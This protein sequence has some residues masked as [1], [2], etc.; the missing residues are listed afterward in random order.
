MG[1]V[2][3]GSCI[4]LFSDHFD[5]TPAERRGRSGLLPVGRSESPRSPIALP[6]IVEKRP[7]CDHDQPRCEPCAP[8]RAECP[9]PAEAVA[10]QLPQELRVAV[11]TLVVGMRETMVR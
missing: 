10:T 3:D 11:H 1:R 6:V 2:F 7:A 8:L 4:Q 5:E 9:K